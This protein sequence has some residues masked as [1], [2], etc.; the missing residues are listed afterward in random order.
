MKPFDR[1]ISQM[2]ES[3]QLAKKQDAS[4]ATALIQKA[5]AEAGLLSRPVQTPPAARAP[6]VDLNQVPSWSRG[7]AAGAGAP[8]RFIDGRYACAA[9]ARD[10][11][12]YIPAR[13]AQAPRALLVMLHGCTQHPDD[14]AAGTGMN[15][16]AEEHGCL[17]LYPAQDRSANRNACWNWFETAHQGAEGGEPAIIAGMTRQVMAEYGADP[18]R[19][20]AAGLSAGGA[21]AAILGAEFP[22]LFAAVGVHSGLPAGSAR[23]LVTG[24]KAM[25]AP[26]KARKLRRG[27]PVIVF[28]GDADHLVN[29]ANADAVLAQFLKAQ[30]A[31]L[32]KHSAAHDHAGRRCTRT[33]WRDEEGRTM[34]EY[35]QLHGAGHAWSGGNPAGSHTDATGPSASAEMLR[36]FLAHGG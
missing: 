31:A 6:F 24:L 13:P 26:G 5:L 12:L 27:V 28:H 15:A 32:H 29:T 33:T 16:L 7:H 19:V 20:Y 34:V 3:A 1:F 2:V 25:R 22:E 23:D 36:F 10:Y 11:K 18:A 21:M 14:F 9:G 35:W 8:G 30:S 17:V 4:A